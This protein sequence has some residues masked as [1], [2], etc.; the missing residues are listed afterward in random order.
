MA[1]LYLA[2]SLLPAVAL[3]LLPLQQ[4]M[5]PPRK[6]RW[7]HWS[8]CN[9]SA[10]SFAAF[11]I[12]PQV[13]WDR[14]TGFSLLPAARPEQLFELDD[15]LYMVETKIA[16]TSAEMVVD[17][18]SSDIWTKESVLGGKLGGRVKVRT[19]R[20]KGQLMV[21]EL[22]LKFGMG[23]VF[24]VPMFVKE[25]CV[26]GIC[27]ED[28]A[29]VMALK[30][31]DMTELGSFEGLLGLALPG[32]SQDPWG[33]TFVGRLQQ[34]KRPV[35]FAMLLGGEQPFM[36]FGSRKELLDGHHHRKLHVYPMQVGFTMWTV[37]MGL[38]VTDSKKGQSLLAARGFGALDSGST[39]LVLPEALFFAVSN[40]LL[41]QPN[42]CWPGSPI[43]CLCD[44]EI[45]ELSFTF[46]DLTVNF[47]KDDLLMPNPEGTWCRF[48]IMPMPPAVKALP[49]LILGQVFLQKIYA[50]YDPITPAVWVAEK[51]SPKVEELQKAATASTPDLAL[52]ATHPLH[53]SA[54]AAAVAVAVAVAVVASVAVSK[55]RRHTEEDYMAL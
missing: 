44:T 6:V 23:T 46:E 51:S 53:V 35:A 8:T 27:L 34:M 3:D 16:G 48:S 31:M 29:V 45:N 32:D 41:R 47:T 21:P 38:N 11:D 20:Q 22:L 19:F 28:Q 25:F 42:Q 14:N 18:G 54:L 26:A 52:I 49:V 15:V 55:T 43:I 4:S 9:A 33:T 40:F 2:A 39:L 12:S 37:A 13:N 17:T 7:A 10:V 5:Q 1:L 50:V 30:V 24:G 36:A